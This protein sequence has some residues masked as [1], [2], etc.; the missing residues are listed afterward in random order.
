MAYKGY[1]KPINSFK[2]L[3]NPT[4]IIYRSLW[5]MK[6][7]AY[8]DSLAARKANGDKTA[9]AEIEAVSALLSSK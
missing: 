9:Q 1:F 2:Y 8:L 6:L 5:E 3:G 4:N 7:M